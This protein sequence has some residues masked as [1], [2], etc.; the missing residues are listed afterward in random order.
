MGVRVR[1]R[2]RVG[3]RVGV[4]VGLSLRGMVELCGAM[5]EPVHL[6][7]RDGAQPVDELRQLVTLDAHGVAPD[8]QHLG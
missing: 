2:V 7:G 5:V 1:V 6:A 3:A 4:R 8:V